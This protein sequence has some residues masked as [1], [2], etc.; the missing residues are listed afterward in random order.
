MK[1]KK[2]KFLVRSSL[3]SSSCYMVGGSG[4]CRAWEWAFLC[5]WQWAP[6]SPSVGNR[7]IFTEAVAGGHR[8]LRLLVTPWLA[9]APDVRA[10]GS[11]RPK[12]R[13]RA[14]LPGAGANPPS[15]LWHCQAMAE[16]A[17][18][19]GKKSGQVAWREVQRTLHP[20]DRGT[21]GL[22]LSRDSAEL[23]EWKGAPFRPQLTVCTVWSPSAWLN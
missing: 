16:V 22:L 18:E 1:E 13:P 23:K 3:H 15:P 8:W 17:W 19:S 12:G 5:F 14:L 9:K 10:V 7:K 20:S 4:L 11:G 2:W 21:E 6:Q